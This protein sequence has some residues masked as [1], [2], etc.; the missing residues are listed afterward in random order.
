MLRRSLPDRSSK[1][2]IPVD[3]AQEYHVEG[4]HN[5][6]PVDFFWSV[7]YASRQT[8]LEDGKLAFRTPWFPFN[9]PDLDY[10]PTIERR[11]ISWILE[12]VVI[13]FNIDR[14]YSV[15]SLKISCFVK[16]DPKIGYLATYLP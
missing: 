13:K 9:R 14:E 5:S 1:Y 16:P 15:F 11:D 12:N 2:A 3:L 4:C 6:G 8:Q 10:H 7:N